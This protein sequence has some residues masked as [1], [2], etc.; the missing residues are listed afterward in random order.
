M[1]SVTKQRQS[2]DELLA[3]AATIMFPDANAR[4][5]PIDVRTKGAGGDT[6]LHVV[7]L[8]GDPQEV[9]LLLDAGAFVDEPGDLGRTPLYYALLQGHSAVA[10]LLLEMGADPDLST[11][12]GLSARAIAQRSRHGGLREILDRYP[13]KQDG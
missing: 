1:A 12:L 10:E 7:A 3:R 2:I 4:G 8:W 9:R 11:E 5:L 13:S 6:A